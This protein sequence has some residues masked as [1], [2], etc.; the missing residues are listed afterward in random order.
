LDRVRA[1]SSPPGSFRVITTSKTIVFSLVNLPVQSNQTPN[2]PPRHYPNLSP[3]PS[4]RHSR[5]TSGTME[6]RSKTRTSTRSE[7]R[8]AGPCHF[9]QGR[10]ANLCETEMYNA[11]VCRSSRKRRNVFC[12]VRFPELE[13]YPGDCYVLLGEE[14]A[15]IRGGPVCFELYTLMQMRSVSCCGVV[16]IWG[17]VGL[18]PKCSCLPMGGMC[19]S[20]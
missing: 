4:D 8:S 18:S 20:V 5:S 10:Q 6:K 17:L 1:H 19:V 16:I 15:G 3:C 7:T 11:R 2:Q 13:P 14:K 12:G 9:P